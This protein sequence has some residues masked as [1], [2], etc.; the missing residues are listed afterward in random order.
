VT[1]GK[2]KKLKRDNS[3]WNCGEKGH[4]KDKCNKPPKVTNSDSKQKCG[5]ANAAVE[6][7]LES[8]AAFHVDSGY[9]S[10]E[11][12]MPDLQTVLDSSEE[13]DDISDGDDDWFSEVDEFDVSEIESVDGSEEL[14]GADWN[15][16]SLFDSVDLDLDDA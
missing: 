4:Y 12:S 16:T 2:G 5:S 13:G 1:G 9:D 3:C 6:L 10:D 15:E 11:D 7:D 8:E 14:S